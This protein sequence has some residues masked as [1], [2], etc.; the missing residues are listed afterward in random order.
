MNNVEYSHLM[1]VSHRLDGFKSLGND[2]YNMRCPICLDSKKN[3]H[4]KRGFIY[5]KQGKTR[6]ACHNCGANLTFYQFLEHIDS[7]VFAQFKMAMFKEKS[8]IKTPR[9][10]VDT[11]ELT[12]SSTAKR[13]NTNYL[14]KCKSLDNIE[15]GDKLYPVKEYCINRKLP[16]DLFPM[17]YATESLNNITKLIPKFA[18][19]DYMDSLCM[20]LPFFKKDMSYDY[21]QCRSIAE[22]CPDYARF[23]TLEINPDSVKLWGELRIDWKEPVYVLE[24]AIDAMFIE[25]SIAMAG[26]SVSS[27][28]S[29]IKMKQLQE[30]GKENIKNIVVCMDNDYKTNPQILKLLKKRLTEGYSVVIY[31]KKFKWKDINDAI[32]LG[33]WSQEKVNTYITSRTFNELRAILEMSKLK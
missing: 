23:T 5:D 24:G 1:L 8:G 13:F 17:I 22:D 10:E 31:D 19:K 28:F 26:A 6:Y 16:V 4:K 20:V 7:N 15:I 30:T 9:L 21:V 12:S 33:N 14:K 32:L 27:V 25:N 3:K 18:D 11:L 29:Y 2:I